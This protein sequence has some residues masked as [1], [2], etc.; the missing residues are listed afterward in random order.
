MSEL[1]I[2]GKVTAA[3]V[4]A[5]AAEGARLVDPPLDAVLEIFDDTV[6]A[7]PLPAEVRSGLHGV[8]FF[9]KDLGAR[10]A[11]RKQEQGTALHAGEV[12]PVTDPF[13]QNLID[14]GMV[15]IGRS[16]VPP[17]GYTLDTT[18][19]YRGRLAITRTPWNLERTAGGS[20][21]GSGALVAAGATPISHATDGGGSIR[22]PGAFN[23]LVG[24]KAS[25]GRMAR[26]VGQNEFVNHVSVDGFVS[27]TVRD[28]AIA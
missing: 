28:S 7:P 25:R 26:R 6:A 10:I 15:P 23:A 5:Q 1:V 11:G 4:T 9:M 12:S 18:T 14:G 24:M 27:R 3:E 13:A 16:T 2:S 8:P 20:S 22:F 19:T 21:G 17:I